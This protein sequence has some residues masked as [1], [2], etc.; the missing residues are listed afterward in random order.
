MRVLEHLEPKN[1]MSIFEDLCGIPH[2]SG[3]TK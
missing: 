1:V 3:N 2:G